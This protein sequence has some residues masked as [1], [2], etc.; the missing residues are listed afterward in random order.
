MLIYI[1]TQNAHTVTKQRARPIL[2][3]LIDRLNDNAEAFDNAHDNGKPTGS[4]WAPRPLNKLASEH[5]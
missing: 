1:S 4:G 2:D 5:M 3:K